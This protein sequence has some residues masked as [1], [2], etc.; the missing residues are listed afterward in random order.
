MNAGRSFIARLACSSTALAAL[1]FTG[2]ARANPVRWQLNMT[3]GV[4]ATSQNVQWL[5]NLALG[6]CVVIGIVVFGAM[7]YSMVKFRKSKGAIAA[8][9]SHNTVAEVIWTIVPIVILIMLAVPA[10]NILFKMYDTRNAELTVK[11]TGYQWL[12]QYEYLDPKNPG[13]NV[14]FTSRLERSS[15]RTRQLGS[16]MDPYKVKVGDENTYLLDVDH[17]LVLPIDTKVRFVITADDVIH[18]WWVPVLGWKQDAI[19]GQIN[20]DWTEIHQPG[21]YRGQ[22]AELCG[23]DHG[24]MPIVVKAVPKAEF[25]TWLAAQQNAG[26][27][28]RTAN[29]T[30]VPNAPLAVAVPATT[31][32]VASAAPVAAH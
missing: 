16:G 15:D 17:P 31:A 24:F 19:P 22:C 20:E 23:K 9:F 25:Q 2:I 1:A 10:T 6:I 18:A 29:A 27:A 8:Q 30:D 32:P 4:T 28:T 13:K 5:H 11:V 14:E 26:D 3:P 21:V 12:W 7:A